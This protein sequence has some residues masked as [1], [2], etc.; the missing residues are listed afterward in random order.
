MLTYFVNTDYD[1]IIMFMIGNVFLF[2]NIAKYMF[3][4]KNVIY[5]YSASE[6][7]INVKIY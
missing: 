4:L 2:L 1:V 7:N 5:I 6:S 3:F